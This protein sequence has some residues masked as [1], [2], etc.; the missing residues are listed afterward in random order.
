MTNFLVDWV[1]HY[2]ALIREYINGVGMVLCLTLS[3][4]ISIFLWDSWVSS[5]DGKSW[6]SMPGVPTACAL[7][8]IFTAE[9]YR[10]GAIWWLYNVGKHN[11]S[12]PYPVDM[13][14]PGIGVF[15]EA[16]FFA[17]FGYLL[18]GL[19]LCFGLLRGIYIFTPP[20][21]KRRVWLYASVASVVFISSPA[22]LRGIFN[23]F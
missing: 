23:G 1:V 2:Q 8:W 6:T 16:G 14:G 7:W 21:W 17:S 4:M 3:L 20:Q 11:H 9:S 18:A 13:S 5:S 15:N 19:M 22:I 10:T 12:S